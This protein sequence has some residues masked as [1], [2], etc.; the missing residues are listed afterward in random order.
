MV[1]LLV[2]SYKRCG[3]VRAFEVAETL[4]ASEVVIATQTRED[5]EA[6]SKAYRGRARILYEPN[7]CCA[8]NRNTLLDALRDG[9]RAIMC[10]DDVYGLR[11]SVSMH[12]RDARPVTADD[13]RLMFDLME[14]NGCAL[15]GTYPTNNH[16]F[17]QRSER[18]SL[19]KLMTG[20]AL[21]VIGGVTP[22]FDTSMEC[23]DDYELCARIVADGGAVLR[24]NR[25]YTCGVS[26]SMSDGL[27]RDAGDGGC[28]EA[29]ASGAHGRAIAE[30]LRRYPTIL[31][32]SSK[33]GTSLRFVNV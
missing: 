15:G 7:T 29:Y 19:N 28:A 33:N 22:L 20:G 12:S 26:N 17:M 9:E 24:C 21:F 27:S 13:V 30:L 8:G 25:M 14:K 2:P 4:G 3:K 31:K 1:R 16:M 18:F 6:Y 23:L 11:M 32:M 5:Y 10:D